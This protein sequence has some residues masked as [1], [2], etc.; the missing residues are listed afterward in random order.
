MSTSYSVDGR[1]AVI[2]IDNPPVNGLS[3]A[4]RE[5]IV[6]DLR[7]ALDDADVDAVVLTGRPGFFSA[8]ADITE[9]GT[10]KAGADPNLPTVIAA[11]ENAPKPVVAA[12]DGAA[13]GCGL[14]LALSTHYSLPSPTIKICLPDV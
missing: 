1:V 3:H 8:G 14:E 7:R 2:R 12:I 11:I 6:S 4:T 5:G 13:L 9:F 10:A